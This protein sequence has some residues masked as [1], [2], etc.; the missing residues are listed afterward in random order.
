MEP[1]IAKDFL[2]AVKPVITVTNES[3]KEYWHVSCLQHT[4]R[5]IIEGNFE[6]AFSHMTDDVELEFGGSVAETVFRSRKGKESTREATLYN[7]GLL[8]EQTPEVISIVSK[9]DTVVVIAK[10]TGIVRATNRAYAC[11]FVQHFTF[12]EGKI[13]KIFSFGDGESLVKAV[14]PHDENDSSI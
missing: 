3:E 9:G 7:Y 14:Q 1:Q 2:E 4:Y 13:T 5:A 12:R 8:L 10:E 6:W 11:H